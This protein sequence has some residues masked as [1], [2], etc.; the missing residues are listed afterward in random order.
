MKFN[1]KGQEIKQESGTRKSFDPGVVLAHIYGGSVRSSK[2]GKKMLELILEG[3]EME[4]FEGWPIDKANPEGPKF[5]GQSARVGATIYTDQFNSNSPAKNPIIYKLLLIASELGVRDKADEI[6]ATSIED[7][8]MK[9]IELLKGKNLY[10]FIKGIEE[11][12]N[13]KTIVKLSLP[14]YKFASMNPDSLDKF[15]KTNQYHYKPLASKSVSGFEP[16]VDE[17]DM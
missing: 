8:A 9:M 5:K 13:G 11:E 7:W 16:A 17:F 1:T 6:N 3:P 14:N 10:F 15:D 12:Y 2:T 4:N